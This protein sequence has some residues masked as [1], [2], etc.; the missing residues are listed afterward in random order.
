[1]QIIATSDII[2]NYTSPEID[3]DLT[4]DHCCNDFKLNKTKELFSPSHIG[5]IEFDDLKLASIK[6]HSIEEQINT[7]QVNKYT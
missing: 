2:T 3:L 7:Q 1:M 6:L 5:N 4:K